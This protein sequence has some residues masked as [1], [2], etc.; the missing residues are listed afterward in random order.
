MVAEN[1]LQ[2][3][4]RTPFWIVYGGLALLPW[5]NLNRKWWSNSYNFALRL[6]SED[7]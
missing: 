6:E 7:K 5:K 3:I 2:Y 4:I 1:K